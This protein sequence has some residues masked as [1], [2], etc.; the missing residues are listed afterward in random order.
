MGEL[1][2]GVKEKQSWTLVKVGKDRV[3]SVL[4]HRGKGTSVWN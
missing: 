3:Y 2:H 1:L 4:L